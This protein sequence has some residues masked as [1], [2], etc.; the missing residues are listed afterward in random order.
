MNIFG[1]FTFGSLIKT[2][3]PGFVWLVAIG[4]VEADISRAMSAP[5]LMLTF[6]QAH[7]QT[8][9]VLAIPAAILLGLLSNMVVFMGIN[10]RLVRQPV[11][12][13]NPAL[14]QLYDRLT[15]GIRDRTW[16]PLGCTD[17]ALRTAFHA[18]AD[19]ELILLPIL[20]VDKIA[21]MREQYWYHLEF[22]INLL[23]SIVVIFLA[24]LFSAAY[25]AG[26]VLTFCLQVLIY[27]AILIPICILLCRAARKN[28]QRH[29][30]KMLSLI[31][32]VAAADTLLKTPG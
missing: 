31:A 9:V 22:Q 26:S 18:H 27:L 23:L 29:V 4:I 16:A 1:A 14:F 32:G 24:L 2:F 17:D 13:D 8:A 11:R 20:G 21:Y 28:Y 7:E 10:D 19:V 3:L 12:R 30:A 15:A 6:I 5:P 25:N